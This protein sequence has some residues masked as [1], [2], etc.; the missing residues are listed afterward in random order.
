MGGA[1]T[2]GDD[3]RS[4]TENERA[5]RNWNEI[6]QEL[7]VAQTGTQILGGFLLAVAFQSRFTEIDRYQLT[8]YLT[9]VVLA[10]I[11]AA[12]GLAPVMLHRTYFGRRQKARIVRI[13]SRLLL[14]D[15]LVVAAL[16]AGVTGL[17]FDFTVSRVAGMIA[18]GIGAL[19][20]AGLWGIVPRLGAPARA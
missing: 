7:R 17:I 15:L 11:A 8:L 14:A 16:A 13:G 6:L 5:D 19:I 3:G 2:F 1:H 20:I 9:L 18:L 10:G 12:L 4:E